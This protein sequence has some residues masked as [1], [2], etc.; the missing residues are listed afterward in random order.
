MVLLNLGKFTFK[1]LE[2][3]FRSFNRDAHYRVVQVH[4]AGARTVLQYLGPG[5]DQVELEGVLYPM[6]DASRRNWPE[7]FRTGA[8]TGK[9]MIITTGS[10]YRVPGKWMF[11]DISEK[12]EFHLDN[13]APRK[14]TWKVVVQREGRGS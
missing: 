3:S 11:L 8:E 1:P 2:N 4:L 10:G 13:G 12:Q 6:D 9:P 7:E 14:V 5:I